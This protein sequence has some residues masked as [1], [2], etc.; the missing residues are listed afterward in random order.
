[1]QTQNRLSAIV[2]RIDDITDLV[3]RYTLVRSD[4]GPLPPFCPGAYT[5]TFLPVDDHWIRRFYSICSSAEERYFYQ[6]AVRRSERSR[7]GSVFWHDGVKVGQSLDIS[8]PVNHFALSKRARHHVFVAGGIGVTPFLSMMTALEESGSASFELHF[9]AKSETN[10]PFY[11]WLLE[12]FEPHVAFYFSEQGERLTPELL[13]R[14]KLGTHVYLCG[15]TQLMSEFRSAASAFGYPQQSIHME[16][17]VHS[18]QEDNRPFRV[19]LARQGLQ[20]E[21]GQEQT[22]LDAL[23]AAHV[24]VASSCEVG[25]CGTCLVQVLDGEVEHRDFYLSEEAQQCGRQM[26]CCVSRAKGDT[27]LLNL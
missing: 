7:G 14:Q 11:E 22:L 9:A 2:A 19:H 26:L 27:L 4:G 17:F 5:E 20:V 3:K 18:G 23:R 8:L 1:M 16:V 25:G 24:E 13:G 15:P 10:C 12:R 6:I 21:V